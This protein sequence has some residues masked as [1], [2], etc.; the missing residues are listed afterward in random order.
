VVNVAPQ[1]SKLV[2]RDV[3][4]TYAASGRALDSVN[5][6]VGEGELLAVVGPN[7][8][9]KS[10]LLRCLAGLE[11]PTDGRVELDGVEVGRL[12]ALE[13]ARRIAFVPQFL[14]AVPAVA[15]ED[16]VMGGR[17]AHVDRWRGP[18]RAD[19]DAVEQALELC[20]A[21]VFRGRALAELSGGQRQRVMIARAAAQS[22]SLV[23]VDEPT[24]SLDP[25]HQVSVFRL[26]EDFARSG[27][28]VV[29][30]THEL[31]LSSRAA[32]LVCV[33]ERGRVRALGAPGEVMRED[34]LRSVY[35][36]DLHIQRLDDGVLVAPW[37][38]R[39]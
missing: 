27:R 4:Y 36:E 30:S 5:L 8:S 11:L 16:F 28:T 22:A 20:D 7:G 18:T 39:T 38:R 29:V 37:P 33:L 15:V 32:Q 12:R 2:A 19:F 25:A 10:T 14:P 34:V 23:V 17:Y 13:R 24:A 31:G 9:G 21:E 6:A 3:G 26:L 35:G 1:R